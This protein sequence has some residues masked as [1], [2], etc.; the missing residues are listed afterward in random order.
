MQLPGAVLGHLEASPTHPKEFFPILLDS[1]HANAYPLND[2]CQ[3][4][5]YGKS[6]S[7]LLY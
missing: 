7:Q 4:D 3:H 2:M 5:L 1:N 6:T